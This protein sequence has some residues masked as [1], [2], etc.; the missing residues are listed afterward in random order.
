ME[1]WSRNAAVDELTASVDQKVNP[2]IHGVVDYF[3]VLD[4]QQYHVLTPLFAVF[5]SLFIRLGTNN[6]ITL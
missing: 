6:H 2:L 3:L 1:G 5:L 4:A